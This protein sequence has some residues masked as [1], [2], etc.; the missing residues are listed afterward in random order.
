MAVRKMMGTSRLRARHLILQATLGRCSWSPPTS[1]IRATGPDV[2]P[3]LYFHPTSLTPPLVID[4]GG[5]QFTFAPPPLTNQE[6]VAILVELYSRGGGW[7]SR[8]AGQGWDTGLAGLTVDFGV[9]VDDPG[10]PS[11]QASVAAT[12][13]PAAVPVRG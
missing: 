7:K 5:A 2:R 9:V 1:P 8:A 11:V 6:T 3:S 12:A 13:P 4:C 10:P